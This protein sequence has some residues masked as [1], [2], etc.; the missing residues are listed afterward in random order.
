M[1]HRRT[2]K[3]G[4][5]LLGHGIQG[6]VYTP[7]LECASG[8]NARWQGEGYVAKVMDAEEARNEYRNSF[9]IRQLDPDGA[10]S[11]LAEQSCEIS[12]SQANANYK[13]SPDRRT[14]LIFRNGGKSLLD[15]LIQNGG[16]SEKF[17]FYLEG[18]DDGGDPDPQAFS[19]LNYHRLSTV[20]SAIKRLMPAL[21]ILNS[22]YSHTDLHLGNIVYDGETPRLIDF[23]TLSPVDKEIALEMGHWTEL[24]ISKLTKGHLWQEYLISEATAD[25]IRTND[26]A[27]LFKSIYSILASKWVRKVSGGGYAKWVDRYSNWVD[28]LH[29][30]SDFKVAIMEL[31]D[32]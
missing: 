6:A 27:H 28:R 16:D 29:F 15:Y 22:K 10:W 18:I 30:R 23:S 8:Y 32:L 13:N 20:I 11:I 3:R 24:G 5:R 1:L 31:P 9:L 14:Q 2:R 7:P 21:D 4:G 25:K 19:Y 26:I 12:P 17:V